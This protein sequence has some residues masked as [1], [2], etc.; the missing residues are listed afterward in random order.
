MK[1]FFYVLLIPV[2]LLASGCNQKWNKK[3]K[4]F[5][6]YQCRCNYLFCKVIL[7]VKQFSQLI[8]QCLS[9]QV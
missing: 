8:L 9:I 1:K 6:H 4:I 7:F 3:N 5:F 2:L